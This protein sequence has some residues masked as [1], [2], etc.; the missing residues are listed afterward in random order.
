MKW[1][2]QNIYD[3][4]SRFRDDVHLE[5]GSFYGVNVDRVSIYNAV[6]DGSPTISL[7]SS[8]TERLEIKAQYESGAQGLDGAI[9]TT[10]T[11]GSATNDGRFT[12]FVDEVGTFQIR[13]HG[14]N[15]YAGKSLQIGNT[16]ILTDDGSGATTL[17]NIDALD[18]TTKQTINSAQRQ[19]TFHNYKADQDTTET[20]VGLADADSETSANHTNV[21]LPL[22]APVA[23][24]LLK[25]YL[26]SNKNLTGHTLTWRLKTQAPGVNY[27]T[28]PST[29]GTQ[30]GAG[31]NN[32]TMTTYDF[33][34]TSAYTG[35]NLIDA[36]DAVFLTLQSNTD[37]GN[38]VIYYITC[39]WE[40]NL[41]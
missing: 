2:G 41:S 9:F 36:G 4:V 6:N 7:G 31:C 32:T 10:Y 12:F 34:D 15:L 27:T 20:Q 24:K 18:T 8:A 39:L 22:T 40:W 29:I 26:R 25:V 21:D 33:S 37:F 11:A 28:G 16:D 30:S 5:G 1:I 19:L 14:I 23:G 13:D 38:N 17:N 35:D 3:Q